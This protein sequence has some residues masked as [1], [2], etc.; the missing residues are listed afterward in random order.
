GL[1]LLA[2]NLGWTF[3]GGG[4]SPIGA[5][6]TA[7]PS[8]ETESTTLPEPLSNPPRKADHGQML[9]GL[10]KCW[11]KLSQ[12][13]TPD[14]AQELIAE[15]TAMLWTA[16]PTQVGAA[17][18]AF[19][20]SGR[21]APTGLPFQVGEKCLASSPTLRVALLDL[22]ERLDM[23]E[24]ADYARLVVD[25]MKEA[26]EVAVALRTLMHLPEEDERRALAASGVERLLN[27]EDWKA[28]PSGGYLEAFDVATE[29]EQPAIWK[30][31]LG[32]TA[33]T[34]AFP[35]TQQAAALAAHTLA[36]RS[37]EFR[38]LIADRDSPLSVSPVIRGQ[39][40]ARLDP[41]IP[42]EL[43]ALNAFVT[44]VRMTSEEAQAFA[45]NFPSQ[46]DLVGFRLITNTAARI[47][48]IEDAA[49]LDIAAEVLV[50]RWSL[51]NLAGEMTPLIA[52]LVI[53]L[54]QIAKSAQH[55]L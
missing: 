51:A 9:M 31:L 22:L 20:D 36:V 52:K 21:D 49:K 28:K 55:A 46:R 6:K 10:E 29:T 43:A 33:D 12:G 16:D 8:L 2:L 40:M 42:T 54:D 37:P 14:Q 24:A 35:G 5:S 3:G 4:R 48:P 13:T 19:L 44:D 47:R 39:L 34:T 32:L 17:I 11:E 27:R 23:G 53:R 50:R 25:A 30:R 45:A 1:G 18:R 15:I 38:A 7:A 41:R 26:D